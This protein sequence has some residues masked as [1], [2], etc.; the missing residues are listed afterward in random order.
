M[1]CSSV[2]AAASI[3]SP[4]PWRVRGIELEAVTYGLVIA[5]GIVAFAVLLVA[6]ARRRASRDRDK[7]RAQGYRSF[8]GRFFS[9]EERATRLAPAER[10][11]GGRRLHG[12]PRRRSRP[13]APDRA[14]D[15]KSVASG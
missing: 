8:R 15:R 1:S 5:A 13:P 4:G 14:L 9:G 6:R 7:M 11:S 3:H 2:L 10:P 12:M